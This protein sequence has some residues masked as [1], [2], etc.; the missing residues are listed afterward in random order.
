MKTQNAPA[1]KKLGTQRHFSSGSYLY[2]LIEVCPPFLRKELRKTIQRID[3]GLI[4]KTQ[5]LSGELFKV[6]ACAS[7]RSTTHLISGIAVDLSDFWEIGEEHR[8]RIK[9]LR[10]MRF[11][12][13]RRR[14]E[15]MLYELQI[16][17]VWHT[18]WHAKHLKGRLEQLKADLHLKPS[19]RR[20]PRL[21]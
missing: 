6:L 7:P 12:R 17:L 4:R 20:R 16:R 1:R 11:P 3:P 13:D 18:E 9:E 5:K 14:F 21:R 19:R 2:D 15:E 8:R 10:D